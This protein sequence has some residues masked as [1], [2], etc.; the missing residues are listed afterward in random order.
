MC[1]GYTTLLR[2]SQFDMQVLRIWTITSL[3]WCK[4]LREGAAASPKLTGT[5]STLYAYQGMN[6][7]E[8]PGCLAM[9]PAVPG[10]DEVF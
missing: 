7:N 4:W 5:F 1:V 10:K 6:Q 9:S 2:I 8:F 3:E